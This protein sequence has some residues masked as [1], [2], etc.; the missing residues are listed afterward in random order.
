M[1]AKYSD[2]QIKINDKIYQKVYI[3]LPMNYFVGCPFCGETLECDGCDSVM[4]CD[5]GKVFY[6]EF[7]STQLG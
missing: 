5:C 3:K 4:K 1:K 6:A 2:G 7:D